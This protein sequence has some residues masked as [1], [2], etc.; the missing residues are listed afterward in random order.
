MTPY[1]PCCGAPRPVFMTANGTRLCSYCGSPFPIDMTHETR[2]A[3]LQRRVKA[4]EDARELDALAAG[5]KS[6]RTAA[7]MGLPAIET[8]IKALEDKASYYHHIPVGENGSWGGVIDRI[9]ELE[10]WR[11]RQTKGRRR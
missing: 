10:A 5:I 8:R 6:E 2:I 1:C 11:E 4:L 3:Y 7:W 9:A